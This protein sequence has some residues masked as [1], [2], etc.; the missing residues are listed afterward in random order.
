VAARIKSLALSL[1]AVIASGV[2]SCTGVPFL[3]PN[4]PGGGGKKAGA[5]A[6]TPEKEP[7]K[8]A[9]PPERTAGADTIDFA[10]A[11]RLDT[12]GTAAPTIAPIEQPSE[13]PPVVSMARLLFPM[14]GKM[15]RVALRRNISRAVLHVSDNFEV[16]S[17]SLSS[18][19][20]CSGRLLVE[21]KGAGSITIAVNDGVPHEVALP[22]TLLAVGQS[23]LFNLG[24]ERYRGSLIIAGKEVFSLINLIAVEDYLRGVLPIEMGK[25]SMEEI[26]ALKAQAV[27]ARTYAYKRIAGNR[28]ELFDVLSTIADQVYGG[29]DVET[30]ES[31]F[32]VNAT[33]DLVLFWRDS[34]ADVYYHSTC[35]GRTAS[36][37][38]V[39]RSP[40]REYLSSKS[41]SAPDGEAYCSFSPA[42]AWEETWDAAALSKIV[43]ATARQTF[44]D[45]HFGG[46]LRTV[47]V[48]ERFGC[49]RVKSCRVTGTDGSFECGG[50]K[51]RFLF[52]RKN[53]SGEILRSANFTVEKNGPD[54][55]VLRGRGY[56]HGVGMCQMGAIGRAR[57]GQKFDQILEAY[58]APARIIRIQCAS[59]AR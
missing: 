10:S 25:R 18:A 55:F 20:R 48:E 2:I 33:G 28:G 52:R 9:P 6:I 23:N 42:F 13:K 39:W 41:D 43:R 1:C 56:G 16:H 47:K 30:P 45:A 3:V 22:C 34:L 57:H 32:A 46:V 19:A 36:V 15:I 11:F 40:Y 44:P 53:A 29:A 49:G 27:A 4:P 8:P 26:E 31:N 24:E 59:S 37:S 17:P 35:G 14:P 5:A 51:L 12:G 58:F 50:D 7:R 21:K 54:I 38:E